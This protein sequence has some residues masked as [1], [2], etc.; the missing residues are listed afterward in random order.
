MKR[1][2]KKRPAKAGL[3]SVLAEFDGKKDLLK[4]FRDKTV[5]LIEEFLQHAGIRYQSVQGRVKTKEK[6]ES[7]YLDPTKTYKQ[8]DDITDQVAIR[9]ITYYEDDVD[10]VAEIVKREFQI[11]TKK[12][13]DRRETEPD[14]FGY[15]A[16]NYICKY[17]P[18]RTSR[19]EYE[20]FADVWCEIQVTS[21]LRHAWSEIQHSWYDLKDAI[22][23]DI[24]RR[25]A[26]MA[27]LLEVAESEFVS[28]RD[29]QSNY[30]RSIAIRVE[31]NVRDLPLSAASMRSFIDHEPLVTEI[32]ES[33]A[34]AR[35]LTMA[36]DLPEAVVRSR[37]RAARLAGMVTLQ[38]V[39]DSLTK[40]A[41]VLSEFAVR[42]NRELWPHLSDEDT[43]RRGTSIFG[44]A[45]LTASIRGAKPATLFMIGLRVEIAWKI[46]KQVAIARAVAARLLR[47]RRTV[48]H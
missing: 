29:V 38:D 1:A 12:S 28:L 43:V 33:I 17:L 47:G 44:A 2:K 4:L 22:P 13:V 21:V 31:A 39:R 42:C 27:A 7:K 35:G 11:D 8:L 10:L 46:A 19:V 32:D 5:G 30:Q 26:R 45:A 41:S 24:K 18:V 36:R 40:Y 9:A 20:K 15:S 23:R 48:Q 3:K 34:L 6:L 37:L 25:F 14:K 16:L